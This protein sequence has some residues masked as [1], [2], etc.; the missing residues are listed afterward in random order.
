MMLKRYRNYAHS[1]PLPSWLIGVAFL[2]V[3]YL[4]LFWAVPGTK[5]PGLLM[6]YVVLAFSLPTSGLIQRLSE[7]RQ[8]EAPVPL[9]QEEGVGLLSLSALGAS[10]GTLGVIAF[11]KHLGLFL[12]PNRSVLLLMLFSVSA[13]L[14]LGLGYAARRSEAGRWG[15]RLS[16]AWL[17]LFIG[18]ACFVLLLRHL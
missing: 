11:G 16:S 10:F 18:V 17:V 8:H 6:F 2:L 1:N 7:D 12:P 3:F 13:L 14:S 15:L 4:T 5:N 9:R